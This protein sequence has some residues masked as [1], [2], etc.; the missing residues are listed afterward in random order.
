MDVT[1]ASDCDAVGLVKT[2]ALLDHHK[3]P[4]PLLPAPLPLDALPAIE[5]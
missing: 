4:T 5:H 1:S 3:I 2:A